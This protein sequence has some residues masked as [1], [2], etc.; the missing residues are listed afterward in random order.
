MRS[1]NGTQKTP[2]SICGRRVKAG[3][4]RDRKD[5]Y[6]GKAEIHGDHGTAFKSFHFAV[7]ICPSPLLAQ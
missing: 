1:T 3:H 6:S 4:Y 7:L 2:L 5:Y